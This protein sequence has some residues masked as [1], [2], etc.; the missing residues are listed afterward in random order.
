MILVLLFTTVKE[1]PRAIAHSQ[2]GVFRL[3]HKIWRPQGEIA[4]LKHC[5]MRDFASNPGS[6]RAEHGDGQI[7]TAVW[8][9]KLLSNPL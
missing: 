1:A 2:L 6:A 7:L 5:H 9:R 3:I 8:L 4:W